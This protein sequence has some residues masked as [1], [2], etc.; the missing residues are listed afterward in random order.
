M[1]P[2][3]LP[4]LAPGWISVF[5]E[6]MDLD[7]DPNMALQ[8]PLPPIHLFFADKGAVFGHRV[9]NWLRI[10]MWCLLE[11]LCPSNHCMVLMTT[12]QWRIALE[13]R[14]YL[15]DNMVNCTVKP[16]SSSHDMARLPPWPRKTKKARLEPQVASNVTSASSV[17]VRKRKKALDR[18]VADRVDIGVRF[19]VHAGFAPYDDTT[20]PQWG[21]TFVTSKMA[22]ED[23]DLWA[24]VVWELSVANFRLELL[25]LDRKVVMGV[26]C[27]EDKRYAA[28]REGK[29]CHI[30]ATGGLSVD[31][32][33]ESRW[34][35]RLV[36]EDWEARRGA[37]KVMAEVLC[38]WPGG[39]KLMWH[40]DYDSNFKA[41]TDF[42]HAVFLFYTV[43]FHKH[44]GR[45]PIM[46]LS[47]PKSLARH[48]HS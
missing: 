9:H 28:Q 12:S 27:Y 26:Y 47:Q 14:Y 33:R 16:Q 45:L 24:E 20:S 7:D 21:R 11:V 23:K 22:H 48:V 43:T 46:P 37:V 8:Y 15:P 29:I 30:W 17:E 6:T 1:H 3:W 41:F 5:E 19:L 40:K 34:V 13:G 4:P 44:C 42:E 36:I 18:R 38:G 39:S 10:R 32:E 2:T 25:Q 31:W 35:D